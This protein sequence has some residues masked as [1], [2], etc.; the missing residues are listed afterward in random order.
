MVEGA[1]TSVRKHLAE[2]Q[3]GLRVNGFRVAYSSSSKPTASAD[4]A[5]QWAAIT[6]EQ[7]TIIKMAGNKILADNGFK[8]FS[9]FNK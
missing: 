6:R 3:E 4:R 8:V 5:G 1:R 2:F 9:G 7:T